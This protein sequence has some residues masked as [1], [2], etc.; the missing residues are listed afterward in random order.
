MRADS[1][2]YG[3]YKQIKRMMAK[4]ESQRRLNWFMSVVKVK[5]FTTKMLA[6]ARARIAERKLI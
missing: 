5:A 3:K 6:R 4:R 2:V 1:L